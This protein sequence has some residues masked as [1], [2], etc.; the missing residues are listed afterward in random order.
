MLK[1]LLKKQFWEINAFYFV[2]RKTGKHRTKV[3]TALYIALLAAVYLVIGAVFFVLMTTF[4]PLLDEEG[5]EWLFFA[6]GAILSTVYGV[7]GSVFTTYSGLYRAKDNDILLAM[8]IP[9]SR[10]LFARLFGISTIGLLYEGMA[11]V[12]TVVCRL[13]GKEASAIAIVNMIL[14]TVLLDLLVLVLTCLLGFVVAEVSSVFK[15]KTVV[16]VIASLAVMGAYFYFCSRSN[17]VLVS[18]LANRDKVAG[19]VR[20]W[21]YPFYLAGRAAEGD[22]L[23]MVLFC[24]LV[25]VLTLLMY[26][27]LSRTFI[28]IVTKQPAVFLKNASLKNVGAAK[29]SNA[30]QALFRKEW[31]RFKSSPTYMLNCALGTVIMPLATVFALINRAKIAELSPL[32]EFMG[33]FLPVAV[34]VVV[35]FAATMNLTATPSVSLEGKSFWL[36]RSLPVKTETVFAAKKK[37]QH[38]LTLP[39]AIFLTVCLCA[40]VKMEFS[41]AVLTVATVVCFILLNTSVGL[42]LGVRFA[43]LSWT[44]ETAAVKQ[45]MGTLIVLFGS[46]FVVMLVGVG[47]FF[48]VRV[49]SGKMYLVICL[50]VLAVLTRL[51][52]GVLAHKGKAMFEEM[53]A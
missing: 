31:L 46:W 5:L 4:L 35:C 18:L 49:M 26:F 22:V 8:P 47:G 12:P 11:F 17:S 24:V 40:L 44:S 50:V 34:T 52:D 48:A 10:I 3:G 37:L 6:I 28:G 2:D 21:L 39:P 38:V 15:N 20:S 16:T 27:I 29:A 33:E 9:P 36:V 30:A 43:N 13:L 1:A 42:F 45:N 53:A 7:F 25:G 19:A 23:S 32:F 51:L 14:L 41:A